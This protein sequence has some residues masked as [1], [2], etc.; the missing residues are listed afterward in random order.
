M[1]IAARRLR[2]GCG[3][4]AGESP[5]VLLCTHLHCQAAAV[6]AFV[7]YQNGA[8]KG[9]VAQVLQ[10]TP[11][12]MNDYVVPFKIRQPWQVH[13]AAKKILAQYA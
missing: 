10:T 3:L 1:R 7:C 6:G 9:D 5:C 11:F 8:N 4:L 12:N 2:L 13:A